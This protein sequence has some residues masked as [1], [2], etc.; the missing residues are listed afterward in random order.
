MG[1]GCPPPLDP[2]QPLDLPAPGMF[3]YDGTPGPCSDDSLFAEFVTSNEAGTS[4]YYTTDTIPN[5]MCP[6]SDQSP[7]NNPGLVGYM[8]DITS[9]ADSTA[10][11][12]TPPGPANI[13]DGVPVLPGS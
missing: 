6:W 3:T 5:T 2:R 12:T 1:T 4:Y 11:V 8:S 10:S 9:Y 13:H 7:Q